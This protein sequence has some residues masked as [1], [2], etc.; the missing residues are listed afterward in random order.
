MIVFY[1][2]ITPWTVLYLLQLHGLLMREF[3]CRNKYTLFTKKYIKRVQGC[4]GFSNVKLYKIILYYTN[5]N[6]HYE[7]VGRGE[8]HCS[9]QTHNKKLEINWFLSPESSPFYLV[10]PTNRYKYHHISSARQ[11]S[12]IE[13]WGH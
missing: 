13:I 3:F 11:T 12:P 6:Y 5:S 8:V 2:D 9:W 7:P 10:P 1:N 4:L